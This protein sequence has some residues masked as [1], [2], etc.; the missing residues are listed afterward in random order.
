MSVL[1]GQAWKCAERASVISSTDER[2]QLLQNGKLNSRLRHII[3]GDPSCL[4][5]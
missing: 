5:H 4:Q 2:A 3:A 1:H